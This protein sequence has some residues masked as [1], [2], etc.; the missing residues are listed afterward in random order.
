MYTSSKTTPTGHRTVADWKSPLLRER[1]AEL[2][3]GSFARRNTAVAANEW[4]RSPCR[5]RHSIRESSFPLPARTA[6]QRAG[7]RHAWRSPSDS[8]LPRSPTTVSSPSSSPSTK[9]AAASRRAPRISASVAPARGVVV[10]GGEQLAV[11]AGVHVVD[12]RKPARPPGLIAFS[13][14][15]MV[16]MN[17]GGCIG[18][19]SCAL[20]HRK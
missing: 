11:R 10:R 16:S 1:S 6:R 4:R 13:R 7:Q 9:S 15:R 18:R 8:R 14:R 19:F 2:G 17:V 20:N 3:D 12:T 5:G